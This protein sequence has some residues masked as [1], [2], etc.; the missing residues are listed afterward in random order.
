[1]YY[2]QNCAS[3]LGSGLDMAEMVPFHDLMTELKA[4]VHKESLKKLSVN[5]KKILSQLDPTSNHS[6]PGDY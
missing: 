2:S 5:F 4:F 6:S 1:M 3:I